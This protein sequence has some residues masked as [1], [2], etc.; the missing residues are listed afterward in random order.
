MDYNEIV[1][2]I[3]SFFET[4][5]IAAVIGAVGMLLLLLKSPKYFLI[6]VGI[7]LG[8]YGVIILL[9]TLAAMTGLGG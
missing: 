4:N 3:V 9:Q 8:G 1:D 7:V 2:S 6:V 5:Q